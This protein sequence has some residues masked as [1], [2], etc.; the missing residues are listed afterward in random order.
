MRIVTNILEKLSYSFVIATLMS[1]DFMASL[2]TD[3]SS[4]YDSLT[5]LSIKTWTILGQGWDELIISIYSYDI[6]F[7]IIGKIINNIT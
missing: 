6:H 5:T 1:M 7:E 3:S 2:K 4:L